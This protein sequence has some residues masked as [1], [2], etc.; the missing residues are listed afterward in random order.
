MLF[1]QEGPEAR[2]HLVRLLAF[3]YTIGLCASK[4]Q[5]KKKVVLGAYLLMGILACVG[6]S[7]YNWEPG[8]SLVWKSGSSCT[9]NE[10]CKLITQ[11][12]LV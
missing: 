1:P 7:L 4:A 6:L 3:L 12:G 8:E 5:I 11:L 10:L 2:R 9:I